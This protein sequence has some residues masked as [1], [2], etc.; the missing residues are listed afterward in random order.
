MLL[1]AL[2]GGIGVILP[3]MS[4]PVGISLNT[5]PYFAFQR[6]Q[7]LSGG[8]TLIS[9]QAMWVSP[10]LPSKQLT[11]AFCF[12]SSFRLSLKLGSIEILIYILVTAFLLNTINIGYS[13]YNVLYK[14]MCDLQ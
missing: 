14:E 1:F 3:K 9:V 2:G 10:I 13:F 6:T 8:K 11:V 4:N 5:D 7:K 12:G